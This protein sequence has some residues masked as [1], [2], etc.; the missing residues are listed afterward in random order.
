MIQHDCLHRSFFTSRRV[1]DVVGSWVSFIAMTPYAATRHIH[2]LHHTYVS[3]L[4]RRDA[5]EIFTM[6]LAE[7]HAASRWDRMRYRVYR[8]PWVLIVFG[9]FLLYT[10][11][12]RCPPNGLSVGVKDLIFHNILVAAFLAGIYWVAGWAG[13][14]F[15]L[16][17]VFLATC[18]G[19]LIPYVVHNFEH[20]HWGKRPDLTF[21]Q[22]A[23][24]GSAVLNWGRVFDLVTLNIGYHDLHHL[25][26][27]IP[28]YYL[29]DAHQALEAAGLLES[30]KIG[31][32]AGVGCL[33]WKL[34]DEDK[35]CMVPLPGARATS[36]LPAE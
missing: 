1:N 19:S 9:P 21:E 26:A 10:I 18:F 34:Y 5:F 3:D 23:L 24:E 6:T 17:T 20:I 31:F 12:R 29:R 13:L 35:G 22:A 25:N 15:W 7:W 4:D 32:W 2:G 8:S 11:V 30:E 16:A 27:K 28:G 33:R 36:P 14:L